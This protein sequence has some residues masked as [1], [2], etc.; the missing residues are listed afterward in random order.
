MAHH[1]V[2]SERGIRGWRALTDQIAELKVEASAV[3]HTRDVWAS[4]VRLVH[5]ESLDPDM[6][7]EYSRRVLNVGRPQEVVVF[8]E[9]SSDRSR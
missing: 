1:A 7:D 3:A 2:N 5:P 4:R 9:P 6:L 8:T